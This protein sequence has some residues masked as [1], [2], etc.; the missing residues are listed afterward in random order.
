MSMGKDGYMYY[1]DLV[2]NKVGRIL[3][4]PAGSPLKVEY[5]GDFNDDQTVDGADFLTWQRGQG[6]T[7][8]ATT[9]DGDA[10]GDGAVTANDLAAWRGNVVPAE[11]PE[12][13]AVDPAAYWLAFEQPNDESA[14][15]ALLEP[16]MVAELLALRTTLNND[17]MAS[18]PQS[19]NSFADQTTDAALSELADEDLLVWAD[20]N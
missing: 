10:D 11:A 8:N 3:F 15:D 14:S 6:M 2:G 9:W 5:P 13:L 17:A 7:E 18:D 19:A 20:A 4:T 12:T 1:V 16:A